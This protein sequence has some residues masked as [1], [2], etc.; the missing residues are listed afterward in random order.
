[1]IIAIRQ[2]DAERERG[3]CAEAGIHRAHHLE[4]MDHETGR[5]E[6][7][8]RQGNLPAH[9]Q[10][11][12]LVATPASGVATPTL[13]QRNGERCH[14]RQGDRAKCN[15]ANVPSTS[16]YATATPS[17][18]TSPRRGRFVGRSV[19]SRRTAPQ[20][21]ASPMTPPANESRTLSAKK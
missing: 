2:S 16:V 12:S 17:S 20:A 11:T 21:R 5:H 14:S 19:T 3:R 10:L 4:T 15:A 7:H 6:E 13:M 9:Q 18:R 1:R 8:Q